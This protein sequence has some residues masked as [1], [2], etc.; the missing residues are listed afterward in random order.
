MAPPPSST[1]FCLFEM[2]AQAERR[3]FVNLGIVQY[4][5]LRPDEVRVYFGGGNLG[6]GHE[7]RLPL[8]GPDD[9]PAYLRRMQARAAE[10][11]AK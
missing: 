7:F 1:A 10:C 8:H 11:A 4:V 9:G 5:E 2:P 3:V 6:S